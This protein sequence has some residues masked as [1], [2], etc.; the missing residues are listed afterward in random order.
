MSELFHKLG[1]DYKILIAQIINFLIVLTVLKFTVYQPLIDLLRKRR[2]K[3]EKGFKDSE[4]A[5]KKLNEID[6]ICK[7]KISLAEKES[8]HIISDVEM[9][10]K[11]RDQEMLRI[12]KEKEAEILSSAK[13][14]AEHKQAESESLVYQQAISLIRQTIAKAVSINPAQ[15]EESLINEAVKVLG[16]SK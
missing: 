1:L 14:I 12:T 16:K 7:E 9:R 10:A 5:T 8:I 15:V 4:E 11:K 13:K 2:E 3:I 6:L